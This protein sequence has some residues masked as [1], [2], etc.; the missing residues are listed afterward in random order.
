MQETS[1]PI[2][3]TLQI[4]AVKTKDKVY[5][6]DALEKDKYYKKDLSSY[7]INNEK[8]N[9]SNIEKWYEISEIPKT[10][11]RKVE[12]TTIN[13][14]YELKE[15]YPESELT[16]KVISYYD[17][18]EYE[19]VLG[20][21]TYKCDKTEPTEEEVDFELSIIDEQ[22]NFKLIKE[23]FPVNYNFIDK[24][25]YN[26]VQLPYKPCSLTDEET[27]YNLIRQYVRENIDTRYAR[28]IDDDKWKF[29]VVKDI[30]LYKPIEYQVD[31]N[32][33][34]SRRKP[35]YENRYRTSK[36]IKMIEMSYKHT[37]YTRPPIFCGENYEDLKNNIDNYLKKLIDEINKPYVE[38][39]C[40]KG[41]GVVLHGYEENKKESRD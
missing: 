12:G 13:Q 40:C 2:T 28:I 14:R 8:P 18:D 22:D 21:Y 15:G 32:A 30:A 36:S 31:I 5:I 6:T 39:P 38:C 34:Y 3:P 10:I 20:L 9:K 16:P 11:T 33:G 4:L 41:H 27:V 17:N 37:G 25:K 29:T 24:L 7:N 19:E 23:E 1:K 26:P 35:K